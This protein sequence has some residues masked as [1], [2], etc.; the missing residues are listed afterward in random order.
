VSGVKCFSNNIRIIYASNNN[1]ANF[2]YPV[3]RDIAKRVWT[4]SDYYY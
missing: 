2:E 1:I 4:N 3:I